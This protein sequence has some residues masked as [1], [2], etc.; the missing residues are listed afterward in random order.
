MKVEKASFPI[1]VMGNEAFNARRARYE[2][3][4]A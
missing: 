1:I 2:N 3:H 4:F